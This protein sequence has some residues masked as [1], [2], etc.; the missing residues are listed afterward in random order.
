MTYTTNIFLQNYGSIILLI[1]GILAGS[2]LGI[3][4]PTI[5]P[6]IKPIGDIFLNLLFVA[7]IPL[8]FFAISSSV[9]N[10]EGTNQL[11]KIIGAMTGVFLMGVLISACATIAV[12]YFFPLD[13]PIVPNGSELLD[14]N[15]DDTWSDKM[16]RFLT[17]SEFGK[18]LSRENML[19]LV[20][21][22]FL[23]GI[24]TRKSTAVAQPFLSFLN[25]GNEVMKNL[26]ILIMK[27]SP[28]GLGAYFAY[29]VSSLGP[30]LFGFYA[31]PLGLYYLFGTCYFF[32][33]FTVF[34]FIA[35]GKYGITSYWKNNIVPTLTALGSCSSLATM[36]ANLL[37]AKKIGVPDTIANVVIPLGTTLHKQGSSISSI[38]KIYVA[39]LLIGKDFFDPMTLVMSLG[40]TVLVSVVAGGIPNG[41]YIGEMLMISV[42]DLPIEAVPAV[43]IIG[44]LVDP[45]ATILNSTG[46]TV[47]SMLVTK[48]TGNKYQ[49][50]T[51]EVL[52]S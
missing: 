14:N 8:V 48:F 28:I 3:Y 22:S 41:G 31:K 52:K 40:I 5:V 33:G 34:A 17:V 27:I 37:A 1:V 45:L 12:L 29:Q 46:D 23:V 47:A 32:V 26:L 2:I 24:A 21:F 18:L 35:N 42:L 13:A 30:Q 51:A 6:Y 36:P 19:A 10:I 43:M 9:A 50:V 38:F 7:V 44:T 49:V 39:F 25:A 11:G 16:V 20:I 4:L 15:P